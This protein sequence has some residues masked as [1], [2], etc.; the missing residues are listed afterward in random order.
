LSVL[1]DA[2]LGSWNGLDELGLGN[3][4]IPATRHGRFVNFSAQRVLFTA[5]ADNIIVNT[6]S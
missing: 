2:N 5:H 4:D 6:I 3:W 1:L